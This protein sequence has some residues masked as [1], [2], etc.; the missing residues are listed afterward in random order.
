MGHHTVNDVVQQLTEDDQE[1]HLGLQLLTPAPDL[2]GLL[3]NSLVRA[4]HLYEV[5]EQVNRLLSR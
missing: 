4:T 1:Q 5:T 3:N 2:I